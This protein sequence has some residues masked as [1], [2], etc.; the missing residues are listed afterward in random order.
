M[1]LASSASTAMRSGARSTWAS[2][3][4]WRH[5]SSGYATSV[6]FHSTR[7]C[8]RWPD[9]VRS[10]SPTRASLARRP[11][12][13]Q[14]EVLG[15]PVHRPGVEPGG[16]VVEHDLGLRADDD[17]RRS[18]TSGATPRADVESPTTRMF[19]ERGWSAGQPVTPWGRVFAAGADSR[20]ANRCSNSASHSDA[21]ASGRTSKRSGSSWI[22][23]P[24]DVS[25]KRTL[26]SPQWRL[27]TTQ[28]AA[29]SIEGLPC[30]R[31]RATAKTVR[32][33][34][35]LRLARGPPR[36]PDRPET[37]RARACGPR[38]STEG[39]L[40]R[41]RPWSSRPRA[42]DRLGLDVARPVC[43]TREGQL[44]G[45][46]EAETDSGPAH[47]CR[48]IHRRMEPP[49][50]PDCGGETHSKTELGLLDH[51]TSK[52][53]P[54]GTRGGRR[55]FLE[56]PMIVLPP[57]SLSMGLLFFSGGRRPSPGVSRDSLLY[58]S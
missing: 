5:R 28:A 19:F 23:V 45:V 21:A 15:H 58:H 49:P 7:T 25:P 30:R 16:V 56:P 46:G 40:P 35:V 44:L 33:S 9:A 1:R 18:G 39:R 24:A 3:S 32:S 34:G 43:D 36:S 10:T 29:T 26:P 51:R 48:R 6:R 57:S 52:A 47:A 22:D 53:D 54:E 12:S 11:S 38:E 13:A 50:V 55:P 31:S 41:S 17:E 2:I 4:S 8:C 27:R 37:C 14:A 42:G 20:P